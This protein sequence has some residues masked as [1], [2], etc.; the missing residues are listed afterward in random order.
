MHLAEGTLPLAQAALWTAVAAPIVVWG[1]RGE[2][3]RGREL[4]ES[5]TLFAGATSLLFAAT[6]LPLPVP[7]IGATSHICLTPLLALLLGVRRVVAA[8]FLVLTLQAIFFAHGGLT[9]LGVN[10]LSLG[11]VGPLAAIAIGRLTHAF[12]L[13]YFLAVA[14][15]CF[16]GDISVYVTD[17]VVLALA[18]SGSVAP[19]T[20]FSTV[21]AAFAPVQVPLAVLEGAIGL[22]LIRM[23]AMRRP[24]YLPAW[25]Q[26]S[27]PVPTALSLFLLLPL[28]GL[29]AG[30][31]YA[32]I[33]DSVFSAT[34]A[35]AGQLPRPGLIDLSDGEVGLAASILVLFSCGFIA[36]RS[37]ERLRAP[38]HVDKS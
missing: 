19:Y 28:I 36:G 8:T 10:T 6:L 30:C 14:I 2:I 29:L 13:H 38:R 31:G 12:G 17:A 32:P 15:A 25:M 16:I 4:D 37:W 27:V 20:T 23:L 18:L 26:S 35:T 22:A 9:T 34:A 11:V 3:S 1:L 21:V 5:R 24:S 7:V 33:D